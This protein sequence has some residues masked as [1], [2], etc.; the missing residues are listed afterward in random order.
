MQSDSF[1]FLVK[2]Y[3]V[4]KLLRIVK[5]AQQKL[6]GEYLPLCTHRACF[7]RGFWRL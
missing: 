6:Q 2:V 4:L 3:E 5:Q 7:M 1:S